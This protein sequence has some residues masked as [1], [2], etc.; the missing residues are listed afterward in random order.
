[1][2]RLRLRLLLALLALPLGAPALAA[3]AAPAPAAGRA[4]QPAA[5]TIILVRHGEKAAVPGNDPPLSAA[6]EARSL[7][8]LETVRR[9]GVQVVVT[10]QLQ[11]TRLTAAPTAREL[12]LTRE[13]VPAGGDVA[14]H[15]R[16]VADHVLARHAG[17]TVL[18]VGHSNT[19]PSIIAALGAGP[20]PTI[21]ERVYDDYFV[22]LR[23]AAGPARLVHARYG[24]ARP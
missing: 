6:G 21:D 20:M 5:T 23:P 16:A 17:K 13:E 22:V 24:A 7:A 19:L 10:T 15:A 8:L 12:G 1:M 14:A 4:A 18:V 11:R 3:Q 9:A 2:P